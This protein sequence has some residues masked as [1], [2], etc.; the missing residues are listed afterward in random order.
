MIGRPGRQAV[1]EYTFVDCE[2]AW[3]L[4]ASTGMLRV[5]CAR[6][7]LALALGDPVTDPHAVFS[8]SWDSLGYI[9]HQRDEY[10][11]AVRCFEQA[12]G[13]HRGVGDRYGEADS[14]SRLGETWLLEHPDAE[15][16]R[17]RLSA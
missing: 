16:V 17:A 3:R 4:A 5:H 14:L 1:P 6:S 2:P 13:L 9:Q 10:A 8:W 12:V 11:D 15:I 7:P